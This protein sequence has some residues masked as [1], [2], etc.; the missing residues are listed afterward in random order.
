M[1]ISNNI[2]RILF[3]N[4]LQTN[5]AKNI[6]INTTSIKNRELK[7]YINTFTSQANKAKYNLVFADSGRDICQ[8]FLRPQNQSLD[9][10]ERHFRIRLNRNSLEFIGDIQYQEYEDYGDEVVKAYKK[11]NP[12]TIITEFLK[13]NRYRPSYYD[14]HED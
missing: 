1:S 2:L 4:R 14:D 11:Y 9:N 12:D 6:K 5:E 8:I 7:P 10:S 3:E 13:E